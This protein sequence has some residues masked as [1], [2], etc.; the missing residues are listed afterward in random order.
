MKQ[1]YLKKQTNN[2]L[3]IIM[4]AKHTVIESCFMNSDTRICT[5]AIILLFF[6]VFHSY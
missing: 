5:P 1:I 3:G 2:L 4:T 6:I